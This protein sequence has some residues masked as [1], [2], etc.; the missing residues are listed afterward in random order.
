MFLRGGRH[1]VLAGFHVLLTDDL[2]QGC[3]EDVAVDETPLQKVHPVELHGL[4]Q[5]VHPV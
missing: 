2:S 5:K 4:L 3:E 1:G